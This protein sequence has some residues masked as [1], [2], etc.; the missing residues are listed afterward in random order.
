MDIIGPVITGVASQDWHVIAFRA[1]TGQVWD[2][3][4]QSWVTFVSADI[5]DY[6]IVVPDI[7]VG[8]YLGEPPA[9]W[10]LE[11]EQV[12]L[13]FFESDTPALT[14]PVR[15]TQTIGQRPSLIDRAAALATTFGAVVDDVGNTAS[16]FETDLVESSDDYFKNATITFLSGTNIGQTRQV[17]LSGGFVASTK[18]ITLMAPQAFDAAPAAGD[19][20]MLL[21]RI[22]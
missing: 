16:T 18:F 19:A 5:D 4:A 7:D 20:F 10:D 9:D 21:G 15:G 8:V 14:N 17:A 1:L 2:A 13:T 3:D 6:V 12:Y 11:N 22:N